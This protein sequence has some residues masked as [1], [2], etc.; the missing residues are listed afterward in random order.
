MPDPIQVRAMFGRIAGRYDLL[1][2]VLTL[3]IDRS[4]RRRVVRRA[5]AQL[6]AGAVGPGAAGSKAAASVD[7]ARIL[8]VCCGSGDLTLD[9][10]RAGASAVGLDFTPELLERAVA[11][12]AG[13]PVPFL[14][15][16]ALDL[17]FAGA[18]FD[19]SSVAFGLRNVADRRRCL[20]EMGRVVRPG[21]WVYV[22]E[23]QVPKGFLGWCYRLYFERI[24]PWVGGLVSR[25]DSAYVY[26]RD[27]VLAWPEAETLCEEFREEG[28][29]EC[30]F[31]R[32]TFGILALHWGRVP[33]ADSKQS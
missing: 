26:L 2:R 9:F 24:L 11:K 32:M 4:W 19:A 21:G 7:D 8:D 1:N 27:T 29:V 3:G 10:D 30:G 18:H 17:P 23:F 28:L 13:R 12:G 31:Q 33:A 15:G 16:D 14:H 22:L 25:D 5:D 6:S 20:R